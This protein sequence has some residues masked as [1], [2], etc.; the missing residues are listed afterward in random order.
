MKNNAILRIIIWS[1]VLVVLVSILTGFL[2]D[3]IYLSDY[4]PADN[5]H[6]IPLETEYVVTPAQ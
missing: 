2:A 3:E 6:L 5:E 4:E 1:L